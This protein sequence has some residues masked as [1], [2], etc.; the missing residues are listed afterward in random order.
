[1]GL[2]QI[3]S[4]CHPSVNR[5]QKDPDRSHR[6]HY[7]APLTF[8]A[9]SP[10]CPLI[11][12]FFLQMENDVDCYALPL[13]HVGRMYINKV[14]TADMKLLDNIKA[15]FLS[16]CYFDSKE[17]I[18]MTLKLSQWTKTPIFY[19][20]LLYK[21][22]TMLEEYELSS[23]LIDQIENLGRESFMT[24]TSMSILHVLALQRRPVLALA[25]KVVSLYPKSVSSRNTLGETPLHVALQSDSPSVELVIF[26][27]RHD[28]KAATVLTNDGKLPIHM[29]FT[30]HKEYPC[31]SCLKLL[32][33]VL[34]VLHLTVVCNYT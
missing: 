3:H 6:L 16:R 4:A 28:P 7:T 5:S 15:M 27:L 26:L 9:P 23:F 31:L 11:G 21:S 2:T 19:S 25:E 10:I 8:S 30:R 1:M 13:V 33:K 32:L 20:Q 14:L 12:S 34:Y 24:I 29:L 22:I 18:R 17:V